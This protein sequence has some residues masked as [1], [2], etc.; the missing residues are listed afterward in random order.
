LK[1]D[2]TKEAL[3]QVEVENEIAQ[4]DAQE[5]FIERGVGRRERQQIHENVEEGKSDER[6]SRST[7]WSAGVSQGAHDV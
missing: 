5:R 3:E 1:P 7:I 2:S 4:F 6:S